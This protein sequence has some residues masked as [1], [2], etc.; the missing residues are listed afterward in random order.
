MNNADRIDYENLKKLNEPFFYQYQRGF[1]DV[2]DSGWFIQGAKLQ[3]FEK[4]FAEY[5]GTEQCA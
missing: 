1:S 3:Q 5:C 2:L 4:E